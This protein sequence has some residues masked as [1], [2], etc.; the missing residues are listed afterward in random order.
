LVL[1][2][3]LHRNR[4]GGVGVEWKRGEGN[5]FWLSAIRTHLAAAFSAAL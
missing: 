1:L 4:K 3:A 5:S 2:G